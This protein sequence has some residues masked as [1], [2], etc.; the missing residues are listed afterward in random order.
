MQV[1]VETTS[2][3]NRKMT[4]H[5]PED[6]IQEQVASRLRSLAGKVKIDGFRPGKVPQSL[7]RKRFGSSVREEVLADMIQ[8]SFYD[9][10]REEKLNP[11]GGPLITPQESAEGQGLKYVA[12]FEVM[13]EFVLMPLEVMEV[14]RF[15]SEVTAEDLDGMILRLREQRKVWHEVERPAAVN[16][17]V[18]INFEGRTGDETFTEGPV[19]NFSVV[20]GSKQLV[21]GFEDKL[22]GTTPGA[23]LAFELSFPSDYGNEKLAGKTAQFSVE[24]TKIEEGVLP[25]VDAAFVK[26]FGI[27]D[28]DEQNFRADVKA[29][30]EREMNRALQA[31]TKNSVMDVLFERNSSLSVPRVLIEQEL[32]RLIEPY[33]QAAQKS[34]Q[35]VDDAQLKQRLEPVAKR[36]VALGLILNKIIDVNRLSVDQKR[37][38]VA[39][40]ELAMSYENPEQVVNWYYSNHDQLKQVESMVLEDQVVDAVLANAKTADEEISFKDLMQSPQED[41]A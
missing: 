11:V 12:D 27:E 14:K 17:R 10:I 7:I 34:N 4:V 24:V 20:L 5:V 3:L 29:N 38:R 6:K 30:M 40:E 32:A 28:G 23:H 31:R 33:K 36:R 8:T 37:V 13:P 35:K 19:K 22:I 18:I 26:A 15:T 41:N 16:D 2:E 9:A 39:V 25:E 21:A 1:S